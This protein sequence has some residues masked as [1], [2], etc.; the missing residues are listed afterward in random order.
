MA[1]LYPGVIV[2]EPPLAFAR[3]LF[4]CTRQAVISLMRLSLSLRYIAPPEPFGE[5][6]RFRHTDRPSTRGRLGATTEILWAAASPAF[7]PISAPSCRRP[8]LPPSRLPSPWRAHRSAT[9]SRRQRGAEIAP[10]RGPRRCAARSARR[11]PVLSQPPPVHLPQ[12]SARPSGHSRRCPIAR[13]PLP[14]WHRRCQGGPVRTAWH[15]L[16]PD[17]P[18]GSHN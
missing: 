16:V 12:S 18:V 6:A 7:C 4:R 15:F 17:R 5:T 2:G 14:R 9:R 8:V 10:C 11:I 3:C 1:E 13:G